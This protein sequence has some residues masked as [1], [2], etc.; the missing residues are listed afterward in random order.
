MQILWH[1]FLLFARV[2]VRNEMRK[3][4]IVSG[5]CEVEWRVK[6]RITCQEPNQSTMQ[7]RCAKGLQAMSGGENSRLAVRQSYY[8]FGNTLG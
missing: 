2:R 7:I 5:L 8:L 6:N 3:Y 1:F 4:V